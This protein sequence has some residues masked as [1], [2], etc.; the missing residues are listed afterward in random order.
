MAG[1]SGYAEAT[2]E[3]LFE[4]YSYRV[5]KTGSKAFYSFLPDRFKALPPFTF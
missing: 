2:T 1:V 5:K 3:Q 4:N